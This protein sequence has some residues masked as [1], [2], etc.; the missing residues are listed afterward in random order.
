MAL[1][2]WLDAGRI[3]AAAL[4]RWGGRAAPAGRGGAGNDAFMRNR[5]LSDWGLVTLLR[6]LVRGMHL[7]PGYVDL[8]VHSLWALLV[9][10]PWLAQ[11]AGLLAGPLCEQV[12]QLLDGAALSARSRR[13][14]AHVHYVFDHNC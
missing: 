12:G 13:E 14:L 9:A 8:Y 11:A 1:V 6:G 3:I 2:L 10:F 7:A 5:D 4:D